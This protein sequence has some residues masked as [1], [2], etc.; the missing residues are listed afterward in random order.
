MDPEDFKD[1]ELDE[2]AFD[3]AVDAAEDAAHAG[4]DDH[5][6]LRQAVKAYAFYSQA[7]HQKIR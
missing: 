5:D 6:Q 2:E 1:V 4:M 3:K 7:R